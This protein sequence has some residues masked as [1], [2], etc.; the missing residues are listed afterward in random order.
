MDLRYKSDEE[1]LL[2]AAPIMDNLMEGSTEQ[3][4][5]KHTKHFTEGAK[6]SLSEKELLKQCEEYQ[7]SHG[8]FG[9]R[10]FIGI[11]RHPEYVNVLWKQR[12]T[13]ASGEYLATLTLVQKDGEYQVIR[14]WVDMWAP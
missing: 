10:E 13:K 1:I 7:L 2:I 12:M 4:W 8:Y 3:D 5:E 9:D 6:A 11:T 14:C